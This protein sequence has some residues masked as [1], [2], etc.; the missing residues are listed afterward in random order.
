MKIGIEE[1]T[2][3]LYEPPRMIKILASTGYTDDNWTKYSHSIY[4]VTSTTT[5]T[6]W[7]LD[8]GGSQYGIYQPLWKWT[9][10]EQQFIK[11][12][13]KV[14][15]SGTNMKLMSELGNLPG[16]PSMTYGIVGEIAEQL[17][18]AAESWANTTGKHLDHVLDL[19]DPDFG[20]RRTELLAAMKDSVQA[21]MKTQ[22]FKPRIRAAQR[23]NRTH[24]A[25]SSQAV[26][27]IFQSFSS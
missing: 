10:Y 11:Q 3:K 1:L 22:D 26:S 27:R 19:D 7:T 6:Q 15:P 20:T 23:Y 2:V 17:D 9:E 8:L 18:I 24:A 5:K 4:R 25:Q 16:N 13:C 12:V 14:H 21:Y